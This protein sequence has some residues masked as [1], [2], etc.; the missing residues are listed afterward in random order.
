MLLGGLSF[1]TFDSLSGEADDADA[2][3]DPYQTPL[4]FTLNI[5]RNGTDPVAFPI[6]FTIVEDADIGAFTCQLDSY[7][8]AI[9]SVSA[10]VVG[11]EVRLSIHPVMPDNLTLTYTLAVD[12][13]TLGYTLSENSSGY[14]TTITQADV[15]AMAL[16]D[17]TVNLTW[18]DNKADVR[19]TP[20]FSIL[21]DAVALDPQP[22][23]TLTT[24][25]Y[26]LDQY[27]YA[28]LP[29]YS[30][31]VAIDYTVTQSPLDN[32]LITADGLDFLNTIKTTMLVKVQWNDAS[33]A[34]ETRPTSPEYMAGYTLL[35]RVRRTGAV[36]VELSEVTLVADTLG[37]PWTFTAGDLPA[38]A[39]DGYPYD[40]M[41]VQPAPVSGDPTLG[42]YS[43][44]VKNVEI[45]ARFTSADTVYDGGTIIN[46]LVDNIGFSFT[47]VWLDDDA[48]TRPTVRFYL[49]RFPK[50]SGLSYNTLSPVKGYDTMVL[51]VTGNVQ[52]VY[53]ALPG[54][55]PRYDA[56]GNE[57][58]YYI[59]ETMDNQGDYKIKIVNADKS[60][61]NYILPDAT[62]TN[63]REATI[64]VAYTKVWRAKA[65]QSMNGGIATELSRKLAG[66]PDT[67]WT[68]SDQTLTAPSESMC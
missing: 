53:Y 5:A 22:A 68:W 2:P 11:G 42:E 52:T 17:V 21:G 58:V 24:V 14:S 28:N 32:Y 36:P 49:Y 64:S 10:S 19:P 29:K 54:T 4:V 18:N 50:N 43:T 20:S 25:N 39:P 30:N 6:G 1:S 51:T 33:T 3:A 60:V 16:T 15:S 27:T 41:V 26:S 40:Y 46:T 9:G 45:Y 55:L 7:D 12:I 66:A 63:V 13:A 61:T 23:P 67:A 38:Y 56:Y 44:G 31:G 35:Q 57:Y 34:L 37:N 65:V 8:T 48:A 59:R 47:K 62:V